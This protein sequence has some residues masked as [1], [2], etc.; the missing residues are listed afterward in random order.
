MLCERCGHEIA[1]N[2]SS[3]LCS[4]CGTVI[5]NRAKAQSV[6][7]Y[8]PSSQSYAG[9]QSLSVSGSLPTA[10]TTF[11]PSM[12]SNNDEAGYTAW[13]YH[14]FN[15]RNA[16]ATTD[17]S[18]VYPDGK[19]LAIEFILSLLGIFGIGWLLAGETRIGFLLLACSILIYWPMMILGT[20][21]T[22]G[23]G[24]ICLGPLAVSCVICNALLLNVYLKRKVTRQR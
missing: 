22:L 6:D 15:T 17:F 11:Q 21:F 9:E 4:I 24:L 1:D 13:S 8:A 19:P 5:K 20:L 18:S 23:F 7:S 2:S 10:Q 16:C 3:V 14:T 12:Q